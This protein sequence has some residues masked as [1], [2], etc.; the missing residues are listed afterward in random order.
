MCLENGTYR[1]FRVAI[2]ARALRWVH[3]TGPIPTLR[4]RAGA[5]IDVQ[6][7]FRNVGA[8]MAEFRER[9][10]RRWK[11]RWRRWCGHRNWNIT[12][13]D[14]QSKSDSD[15]PLPWYDFQVTCVDETIKQVGVRSVAVDVG[16][17]QPLR[18]IIVQYVKPIITVT[19]IADYKREYIICNL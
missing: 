9:S 18:A 19:R 1:V 15:V 8:R 13:Q 14:V 16:V 12:T 7:L 5:V 10:S 2:E 11:S 3:A 4:E 6:M 17:E